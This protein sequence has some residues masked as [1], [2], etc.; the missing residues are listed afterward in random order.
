YGTL[1]GHPASGEEA[2]AAELDEADRVW[3]SVLAFSRP[4][5][6]IYTLA[7]PVSRLMQKF[8]TRK[9]LVAARALAE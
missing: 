4:R 6:G 5:P 1:T 2:F 3:F 9:Y 8:V 7:A